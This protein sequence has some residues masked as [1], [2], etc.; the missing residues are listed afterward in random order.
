[1][2]NQTT[3]AQVFQQACQQG[4]LQP[5]AWL[6]A[7][8]QTAS[9]VLPVQD[10]ATA[11]EFASVANVGPAQAEALLSTAC[12]AFAH[13]RDSSAP[14]RAQLLNRWYQL[15][16]DHQA[17]LASLLSCEAGKPLS[18]ADAEIRYAADYIQWF[19]GEALRLQGDWLAPSVAG[20]QLLNQFEPVG[21]VLAITPWNFPAAMV[22]RKVA[23]AIAAG[24]AVILK[25]S[26]LTPLSALA[27]G[28]LLLK[29]GMP[30]GLL[31]VVPST[32][33]AALTSRLMAEPAL[34]KVSF[35]G[36][37]RVGQ[38]L[39]AQSATQLQRLSLELGGNAP[40]LV[41]ADADLDQAVA[42][43]MAAKFRNAGQTCV[44][45]NRVLVAQEVAAALEEKLVLAMQQLQSGPWQQQGVSLGPLISA[46]AQSRV[47][48]LVTQALAAGAE[49]AWQQPQ[50]PASGWFYP[51]TLLTGV[52]MA[53]AICQQEI[54]GP[55][56]TLQ[57]FTDE[58]SALALANATDAGLAAYLFGADERRNLRV[59]SALR[60]GM[61]GI[62]ATAISDV[63]I[64]FGGVQ[65]S[66][67]GREGSGYGLA[68]YQQIKH[69]C[70]QLG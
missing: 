22:T 24:C 48:Q 42:G 37:T 4:L 3:A 43:I 17:L 18:E 11:S 47:H 68:E 25:P 1:M 55:V 14:A 15:V 49:L 29:A 10:P 66:G 53:M 32:D 60:A 12:A 58:H 62:N 46:Q 45:V 7:G 61:V 65:A 26:E 50:I 6:G 64:P 2:I 59:A 16:L 35:T 27:L 36:S 52:T 54:F 20:R 38:L 34:R 67:F 70:W 41:F 8:W 21:V 5:Q 69:V 30:A 33:A 19:A 28:Q 39:L 9:D 63:R 57:T 40:L 31:Q 44:C 13:W 51:A 56:L 23:A